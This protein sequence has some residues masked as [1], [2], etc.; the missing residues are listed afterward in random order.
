M[1]ANP[2]MLVVAAV[3][4]LIAILVKAYQESETFRAIVDKLWQILKNSLGRAFDFVTGTIRRFVD[5]L[6]KAW[7]WAGRMIQRAK[8]LV[9]A[10]NPFSGHFG[11]FSSQSDQPQAFTSA[12]VDL[13]PFLLPAPPTPD[14]LTREVRRAALPPS[15][16][17]FRAAGG[18]TQVVEQINVTVNGALDPNAVA[19]QIDRLLKRR[20][21]LLGSAA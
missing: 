14:D 11:D 17:G 2:V 1:M 16:S 13:T 6:K 5:M 10:L 9:G 15:L 20:A 3:T 12:V 18:G 21:R 19:E 4:A 7:D 8:D